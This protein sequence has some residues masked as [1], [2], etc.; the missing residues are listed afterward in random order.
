VPDHSANSQQQQ[1]SSH[2]N[3]DSNP[4]SSGNLVPSHAAGCAAGRAVGRAVLRTTNIYDVGVISKCSLGDAEDMPIVVN[5]NVGFLKKGTSKHVL[6]RAVRRFQRKIALGVGVDFQIESR[7][8]ECKIHVFVDTVCE[9]ECNGG[10]S[11]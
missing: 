10:I 1:G 7:I 6:L 2:T 11:L 5:N 8:R 3:S 9:R 4:C